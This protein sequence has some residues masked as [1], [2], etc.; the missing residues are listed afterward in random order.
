MSEIY[1][2]TFVENRRYFC[3]ASQIF[4]SRIADIFVSRIADM[5]VEI[6]VGDFCRGLL[7]GLLWAFVG[8]L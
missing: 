4:L 3:R 6:Y 7:S 1:V 8:G 2:E 5:F